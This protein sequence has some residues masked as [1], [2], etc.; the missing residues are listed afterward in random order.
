[1]ENG[2]GVPFD[3]LDLTVLG[4][5]GPNGKPLN[6]EVAELLLRAAREL[7]DERTKGNAVI[8]ITISVGRVSDGSVSVLPNVTYRGPKRKRSAMVAFVDPK[9]QELLTQ[10]HRQLHLGENVTPLKREKDNNN[11]G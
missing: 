6:D 10:D 4:D 11:A 3:K 2:G 7:D 5:S 9:R 8:S 1:M